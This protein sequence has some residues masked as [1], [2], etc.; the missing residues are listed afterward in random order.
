MNYA[1]DFLNLIHEK[2]IITV[3]ILILI[4]YFVIGGYNKQIPIHIDETIFV[5]AGKF[6]PFPD[7]QKNNFIKFTKN[8]IVDYYSTY[9]PMQGIITWFF[10]DHTISQISEQDIRVG[11]IVGLTLFLGLLVVYLIFS[12]PKFFIS[13]LISSFLLLSFPGF[14]MAST[15]LNPYLMFPGFV[16]LTY[17]F[18]QSNIN[19]RSN[20]PYYFLFISSFFPLFNYQLIFL[21][22][23]VFIVVFFNFP[24]N[25]RILN[26]SL[27]VRLT[28][29]LLSIFVIFISYMVIKNKV[30]ISW[31]FSSFLFNNSLY[32][33]LYSLKHLPTSW[34]SFSDT[35]GILFFISI[36]AFL[37]YLFYISYNKIIIDKSLLI[38][39]ITAILLIISYFLRKM[40]LSPTRH[41]LPLFSIFIIFIG[42]LAINT[43]V[44]QK[45]ILLFISILLMILGLKQFNNYVKTISLD[46]SE[47]LKQTF[48]PYNYVIL[49]NI[50]AN[51][52]IAKNIS[53]FPNL[54]YKNISEKL[55]LFDLHKENPNK[56]DTLVYS[57]SSELIKFYE[58]LNLK[59]KVET[60]GTFDYEFSKS[61]SYWPQ[62]IVIFSNK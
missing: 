18:F 6:T 39:L 11:R 53:D 26:R 50:D 42:H 55:L 35:I 33:V 15:Q 4:I 14:L 54:S 24:I 25:F 38:L 56:N 49:S 12:E 41:I 10:I 61:V 7:F 17:T 37:S 31:W 40:P 47:K 9:A 23:S 3:S 20:I 28:L 30:M 29:I 27:F 43:S 34:F 57:G 2:R 62:E 5:N 19:M 46:Y 8:L 44:K 52:F 1:H 13:R 21:S 48:E 45:N 22:I 58:G 16:L 59:P 32:S 36:I 51:V 60:F